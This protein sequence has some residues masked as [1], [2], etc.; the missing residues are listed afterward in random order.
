MSKGNGWTIWLSGILATIVFT[1]LSI[2]GTNLI[3][4][5]KESRQRDSELQAEDKAIRGELV[6]ACV[7][8]QRVNSDILVAVR[9]IQ[10]DIKY[11]K[12]KVGS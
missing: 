9:E 4:T 7:D 8:Q 2:M 10:T 1:I 11:I 12:Q 3:A 5:D 6:K